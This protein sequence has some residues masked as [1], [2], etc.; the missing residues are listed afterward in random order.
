MK[1]L[2][3]QL[4]ASPSGHLKGATAWEGPAANPCIYLYSPKCLMEM[5][6]PEVFNSNNL[7]SQC[8]LSIYYVPGI[9]LSALRGLTNLSYNEVDTNIISF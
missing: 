8:L 5:D 6:R 1:S 9:I 7:S 4:V 3:N 2:G